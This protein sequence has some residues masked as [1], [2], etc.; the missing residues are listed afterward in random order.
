MEPKD[1]AKLIKEYRQKRGVSQV[2]LADAVGLT[3]ATISRMEAGLQS[4]RPSHEE[5]ILLH[6]GDQPLSASVKPIDQ[7]QSEHSEKNLVFIEHYINLAKN[8]WN[9][10]WAERPQG[11]TTGGDLIV[12]KELIKGEKLGVLIAD[13]VGH[14]PQS[15][16]MAFALELTYHTLTSVL[17]PTF[18]TTEFV[19]RSLAVGIT[20]TGKSWKGEPS[21]GL[22]NIS[23][24]TGKFD[25]INRGLPYPMILTSDKVR[26]IIQGRASAYSLDSVTSQSEQHSDLIDFGQTLIFFTD[27]FLDL[28]NEE[29]FQN[30]LQKLN[31]LFKGDSKAIGKNI[32]RILQQSKNSR[33]AKDDIS[34]LVLSKNKK[35]K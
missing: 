9:C 29:D 15:A 26:Q 13:S 28:I 22:M 6:I 34:F 30:Q 33:N 5:T 32:I 12:V 7:L 21:I 2:G 14:G 18:I 24:K 1:L 16:Y 4:P 20:T 11:S 35:V 23:L 31:R 17:S 25:L 8:S 10:F 27:G 3:Q 19:D